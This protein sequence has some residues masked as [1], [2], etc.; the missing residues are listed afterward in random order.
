[1]SITDIADI[2]M[3]L[4]ARTKL[5]D[6]IDNMQLNL[7]SY[8]NNIDTMLMANVIHFSIMEC[9]L[10]TPLYFTNSLSLIFTCM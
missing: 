7:F 2:L 5:C 4:D 10:D 8:Q 6:S 3:R 9:M 1:M